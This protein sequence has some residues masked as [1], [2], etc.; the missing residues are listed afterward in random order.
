MGYTGAHGIVNA[1]DTIVEA[2]RILQD[3]G[4]DKVHF[5]MVGDGADKE[6]LVTKAERWRL[7]QK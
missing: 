7:E 1:L 4:V 6:R 5:L 2:A 3:R